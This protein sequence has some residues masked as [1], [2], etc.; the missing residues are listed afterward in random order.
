MAKS[1]GQKISKED[2]ELAEAAKKK[3]G[4]PAALAKMFGVTLPAASEW[5]R[6]RPIPRHA[7]PRLEDY[8]KPK[9]PVDAEGVSEPAPVSAS[10]RDLVRL[11]E[12]DRLSGR[13]A[14]LPGQY[15]KRYEERVTDVVAR[16]KRELE[17]Y[18]A[19]LEAEHR[20][21]P[22]KRKGSSGRGEQ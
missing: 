5:G 9:R 2:A 13:L 1:P 20:T 15:R 22:R 12:P 7:R 17:E 16:V 11:L 6:I 19:L 4:G 14:D 3:A 8:V 10:V 21:G 18:Q